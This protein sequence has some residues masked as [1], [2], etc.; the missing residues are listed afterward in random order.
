MLGLLFFKEEEGT[1]R[2]R[3]GKERKGKERERRGKTEDGSKFD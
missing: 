3:K 1:R 2:Q